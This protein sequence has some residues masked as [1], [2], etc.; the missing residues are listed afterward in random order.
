LTGLFCAYPS[1]GPTTPKRPHQG[2]V[3]AIENIVTPKR[4]YKATLEGTEQH[5]AARKCWLIDPVRRPSTHDVQKDLLRRC[6]SCPI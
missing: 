6:S 3:Q 1:A 5:E 2:L 4:I